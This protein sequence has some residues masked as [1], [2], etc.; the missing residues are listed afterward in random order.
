[1]RTSRVS[2]EC[3]KADREEVLRIPPQRRIELALELGRNGLD[4]Y[5]AGAGRGLDPEQA[6]RRIAALRAQGRR[7]C[8]FDPDPA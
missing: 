3:A 2:D 8:S 5:L 6:V 7:P 4:A 1:V